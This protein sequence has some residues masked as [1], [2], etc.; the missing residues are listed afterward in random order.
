LS[1]SYSTYSAVFPGVRDVVVDGYLHLLAL[2]Q[3]LQHLDQQLHVE[4]VRVV[5]VV[6]IADRLLKLLLV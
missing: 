5:E 2:T 1:L 3:S 4:R 6:F